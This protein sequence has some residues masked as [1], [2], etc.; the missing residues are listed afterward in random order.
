M[1]NK[2]SLSKRYFLCNINT[3]WLYDTEL[4]IH[5]Y[6]NVLKSRLRDIYKIAPKY[7][8]LRTKHGP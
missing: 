7:K 5:L 1:T 8:K 6:I 2:L 3:H 4:Y